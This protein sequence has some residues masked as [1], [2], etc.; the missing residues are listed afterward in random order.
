MP[1]LTTVT[2]ALGDLLATGCG[3]DSRGAGSDHEV[4]RQL[5]ATVAA[6]APALQLCA[7]AASS[8]AHGA[9]SASTAAIANASWS[10]DD[11]HAPLAAAALQSSPLGAAFAAAGACAVIG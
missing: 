5:A 9:L 4:E 2:V 7:S 3:G 1:T 6:V 10:S 8:L 11:H